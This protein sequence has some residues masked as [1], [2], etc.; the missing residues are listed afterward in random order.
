MQKRLVKFDDYIKK[1]IVLGGDINLSFD[2]KFNASGGNT[3]SSL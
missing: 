1:N 3:I 2:Q